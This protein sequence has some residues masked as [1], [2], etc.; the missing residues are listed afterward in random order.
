MKYVLVVFQLC[1]VVLALW[2]SGARTSRV[3][4]LLWIAAI[5]GIAAFDVLYLTGALRPDF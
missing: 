1:V 5:A 4:G 3:Y 2:K